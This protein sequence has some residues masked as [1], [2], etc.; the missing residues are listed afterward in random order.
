MTKPTR[1]PIVLSIIALVFAPLGFLVSY[2]MYSPDEVW[3]EMPLLA[4]AI[5]VAV[6]EVAAAI[7]T[8]RGHATL[9]RRLFMTYGVLALAL[10]A[11]DLFYLFAMPAP[12]YAKNASGLV[13]AGG[14]AIGSVFHFLFTVGAAAWT[15]VVI[16]LTA[17]TVRR[18]TRS[19][20]LG[21]LSA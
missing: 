16:T 20:E 17:A 9:G 5:A 8:L 3:N 11:V 2:G 12:E 19:R 21:L 1:A 13:A 15:I 18:Q 7:A 4:G 6:A 14:D 10:G